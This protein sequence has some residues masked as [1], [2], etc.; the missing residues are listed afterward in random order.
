MTETAAPAV[1]VGPG[2]ARQAEIYRAGVFGRRPAVPANFEEL[3]RRAPR[4][5]LRRRLGVRRGRGRRGPDHAQQPRRLRP[6]ADR[7]ADG[8]RHHPARPLRRP[9][10]PAPRRTRP[11]RAGR[12]RAGGPP[13][14][15][16]ARREGGCRGGRAVRLHQPGRYADGGARRC[17]GRR[18]PLGAALLEHRRAAGRQPDPA[19]GGD[20]RGRARRHPRHHDP[21]LAAAG[22]QPRLAAVRAGDGHR[23]VHLGPA[24]PRAR[25]RAGAHGERPA[26]ED[27]GD[28]PGDPL[29]G[30]DHAGTSRAGSWT[31]CARRCRAP[32]WRPSST[33]TPTPA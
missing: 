3:E 7:A 23:A 4:G 11:A 10:R 24:F 5:L 30:L 32:P 18:R 15:R 33:S 29:A 8:A 9:A 22:P 6:L 16:P 28:P 25:R 20:R 27:R 2:R 26:R 17:D 1:P 12:R 13:R 19:R 14:L 21:R 31:T